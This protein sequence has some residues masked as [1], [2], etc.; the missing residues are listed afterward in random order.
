MELY[1]PIYR[2]ILIQIHEHLLSVN[3]TSLM[4]TRSIHQALVEFLWLAEELRNLQTLYYNMVPLHV[5]LYYYH[6][7]C[8]YMSEG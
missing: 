8:I 1:L 4:L 7:P 3:F 2:V 5:R 6:N